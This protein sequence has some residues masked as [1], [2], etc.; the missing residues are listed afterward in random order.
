MNSR[1]EK[2]NI[3]YSYEYFYWKTSELLKS[4]SAMSVKSMLGR[5]DVR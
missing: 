4:R 5:D 2:F 3:M 1:L